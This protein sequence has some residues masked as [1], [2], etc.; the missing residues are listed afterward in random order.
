CKYKLNIFDMKI[1]K[2]SII[3]MIML[4]LLPLGAC[5]VM[6]SNSGKGDV[7]KESVLPT[8]REKIVQAVSAVYTSEDLEKG[9]VKGD[10]A[11]EKVGGKEAVGETAPY[12]KFVP[13]EKRVYGNNGC[14]TINAVYAYNPADSTISFTNLVSTMMA[15]GMEGITDMEINRA[16]DAT[17]YYT[18]RLN[19][20][21]Y[22]LTFYDENRTQV[23]ELMHQN[24][25]FLNGTWAVREIDG[26]PIDNPDMK[27]VIDVDENKL[28]GN[29]GCNL[30]NGS[31]ETD[32]DAANSISF[33]GIA[34]TRMACPEGVPETQFVMALEEASKAKPLKDNKVAL[35]NGEGE[36]VMVLER[37][38]DR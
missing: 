18:W 2:T 27:L 6:K 20:D 11:I 31:L 22:Y 16:L 34:L 5:G 35:I 17:R 3:P 24:F 28:H 19:G 21:D 7:K 38:S 32:M 37:T 30:L 36:T 33:Q 1:M 25:Q 23:M 9:I 10:W 13:A 12:L 15:C 26:Q 14:N 29:T 4:G 8:D